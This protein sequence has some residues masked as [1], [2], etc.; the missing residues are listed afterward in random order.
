MQA[1]K[2]NAILTDFLIIGGGIAGLRAAIEAEKY[3]KVIILNKGIKGES[4]SD[5]AQGG[6]AAALGDDG[7]GIQ[8]H[9]QDT[10]E[11]GMG[12]C[13]EDAVRV[14]VEE[15]PQRVRELIG[16]GAEFDRSGNGFALA[17]EGA[18]RQSR[19]LRAKGDATGYEIVRT[20]HRV[21]EKKK[22]ISIRNGHFAMDLVLSPYQDD[23][24]GQ[25]TLCQGA[26]V[27][28]E[29]TE[30]RHLFLAQ[31]VILATGGVGQVYKKTTNPLVA[32]G[33]GIGLALAAGAELSDMEFF[34]FHPTA[35]SLPAAP[36]FLLSEAMRGE[37]AVLR[38]TA[39]K[40]FMEGY[41]PDAELAPRDIVTRAIVHEMHRELTQHVF[42]DL[43]HL[44]ST[45]LRGRFPKID[46][47]CLRY[48]IDMT[49]EPIPVAPS[50]HYL[51]GGVLTNL[52]GETSIP[53]LYAVGEVA[54]TGVHGA[55]RLA[56]NSLLEGLVF[57]ARVGEAVGQ[58]MAIPLEA[59]DL[60]CQ[61]KTGLAEAGFSRTDTT[62]TSRV[63][64]LLVQKELR[65][66]MWK[67]VGIIRSQNSLKR[68]A[69]KWGRWRWVFS[70]PTLTRL[71][72]ETKNM[73][74]TS[75]AMIESALRRNKSIGA[76]FLEDDPCVTAG[77]SRPPES[78]RALL[79]QITKTSLAKNFPIEETAD[80]PAHAKR[81]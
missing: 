55:N 61:E 77:T 41:H 38:N 9:Y 42:L 70:R 2:T 53:R 14:L 46:A 34:Q 72:S 6:V 35:L 43:T 57:G 31:T 54:C 40:Q 65:E 76:H 50:A 69:Q 67:E 1:K 15:G 56:S 21:I 29:R 24:N 20:L 37:G 62:S 64:Y 48:G 11:A 73:L 28:D 60:L 30:D 8:S 13:Q 80:S 63:E 3:G 22:N 45:F 5:F 12:L 7:E 44:D 10:V 58:V 25:S 32:T 36:S 59:S 27:L 26:W 17:R 68:A 49:N 81:T 66:M 78:T 75:A 23:G 19:I 33:D 79:S 4:S 74:W 47:T 52:K 51:M 39:G 16:W 18:H 71:A